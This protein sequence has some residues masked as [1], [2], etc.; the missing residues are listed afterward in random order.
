M[1][2]SI[3][4]ALAA[5]ALA[6]VATAYGAAP[7]VAEKIRVAGN[8]ATD[9]S[10]SLAMERFKKDVES[11]TGGALE[12]DLFPAMQLGGAQENVDQVRSGAVTMTWIGMAYLSRTV[13]E[14]EAVSLPFAF[15]DRETAFRVIDGKATC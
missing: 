1:R 9:H 2:N 13:P 8:F 6:A 7:A 12:V 5:A 4:Q 3:R 10:S 14:L 15:P 11:A